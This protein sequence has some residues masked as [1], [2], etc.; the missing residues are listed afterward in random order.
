[1]AENTQELVALLPYVLREK[2]SYYRNYV[3]DRLID[4]ALEEGKYGRLKEIQGTV[5]FI[6]LLR[7]LYGYFVIGFRNY[8]QMLRY[9]GNKQVSGF[10]IGSTEFTRQSRITRQW[11]TVAGDLESLVND[12]GLR[13][14]VE[15]DNRIDNVLQRIIQSIPDDADKEK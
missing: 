5:D 10:Q 13:S 1:M 9:F 14:Y 4:L 12:S 15:P 8:D 2:F 3:N 7:L 6:F 11:Q